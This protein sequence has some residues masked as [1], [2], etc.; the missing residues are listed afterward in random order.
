MAVGTIYTLMI[1]KHTPSLHSSRPI[2]ST[3]HGTAQYSFQNTSNSISLKLNSLSLSPKVI[4]ATQVFPYIVSKA[5]LQKYIL[6][7]D[8]L[9]IFATKPFPK[10]CPFQLIRSQI[11]LLDLNSMATALVQA[12]FVSSLAHCSCP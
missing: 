7:S 10:S 6:K 9:L 3:Y 5:E 2:Q 4:P 12:I 8:C 1:R 11:H